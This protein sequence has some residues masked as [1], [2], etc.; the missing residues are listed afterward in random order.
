M[1]SD[2]KEREIFDL[3]VQTLMC[4][5]VYTPTGPSDQHKRYGVSFD[6][7]LVPAK[8]RSRLHPLTV[9]KA[10]LAAKSNLAPLVSERLGRYDLMAMLFQEA[11][12][13]NVSRDRLLRGIPASLKVEVA[14]VADS[15]LGG[16]FDTLVILG[17]T[18]DVDDMRA[19]LKA[20]DDGK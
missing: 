3:A 14:H 11:D 17:V 19:A 2:V 20:I 13:R 4:P 8:I 18:L 15:R 7:G 10:T 5:S 1:S 9:A 16:E 12:V 6:A